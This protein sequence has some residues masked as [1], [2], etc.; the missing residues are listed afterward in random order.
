MSPAF[1]VPSLGCKDQNK[2]N[3]IVIKIIVICLLTL[4]EGYVRYCAKHFTSH[5]IFKKLRAVD[6]YH[7]HSTDE[8]IE[9]QIL[10][11]LFKVPQLV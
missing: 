3:K 11:N 1:T 9:R 6:N 7:S 8:E 4:T 2:K 10:N 5:L